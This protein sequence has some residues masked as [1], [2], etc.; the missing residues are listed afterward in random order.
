MTIARLLPVVSGETYPDGVVRPKTRGE[1]VDGVRPCP[2]ASCRHHLLID[3]VTADLDLRSHFTDPDEM[4]E[5]CSLDVADRGAARLEDVATIFGVTRQLIQQ[6]EKRACARLEDELDPDMLNGWTHEIDV[7]A[8]AGAEVERDDGFK[9]Q[10]DAAFRRIVPAR[11]R[12]TQLLRGKL[13]TKG[14][15]S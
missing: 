7:A 14:E 12:G 6:I 1:C 9:A 5:T 8:E 11:E 3:S 2:W 10:V 4:S 15:A 13:P